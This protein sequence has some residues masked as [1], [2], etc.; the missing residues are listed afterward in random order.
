MVWLTK[1][2]PLAGSN[3]LDTRMKGERVEIPSYI[4]RLHLELDFG[5]RSCVLVM[6]PEVADGHHS[7]L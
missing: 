3:V 6:A 7:L 5:V 1:K 4:V 2:A